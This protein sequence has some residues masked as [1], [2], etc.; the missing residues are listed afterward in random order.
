MIGMFVMRVRFSWH[1]P[2][3]DDNGCSDDDGG[4]D[5]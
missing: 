2:C 3:H 1:R 5:H 4:G